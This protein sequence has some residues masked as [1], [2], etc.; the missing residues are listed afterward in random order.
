MQKQT[1]IFVTLLIVSFSALGAV[2]Y[3]LLEF[4]RDRT[5]PTVKPAV[6]VSLGATKPAVEN[7][8]ASSTLKV[9]G[10]NTVAPKQ[11]QQLPTSDKFTDY[12]QFAGSTVTQYQ[13][14]I[15]GIGKDATNGD[16]VDVIYKG[17]LTNGTLFD[18]SRTNE[19]N[20]LVTFGFKIGA[21]QVIPGWEQGIFG[22]KE[23]GKRRLVIPASLG[24]GEAGQG[25]IPPNSM[26]IF[27][28]ELIQVQKP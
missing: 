17:W 24:Y 10:A 14:V 19:Q 6:D 7:K 5:A 25:P 22:M 20:Q 4:Q 2:A 23:G 18:Q 21:G 16:S 3:L 11:Q 15:V 13:D 8:P 12:E 28:V 26:L 1:F 9:Q 27:D